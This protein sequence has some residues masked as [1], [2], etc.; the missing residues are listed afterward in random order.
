MKTT[1]EISDGLLVEAKRRAAEER[2]SLRS[3]I[4]RGLREQLAPPKHRL[5]PKARPVVH[6]ITVDGGLPEGLQ[7]EDRAAMS[8]WLRHD[9]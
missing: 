5:R 1:V 2:C 6:W 7:L 9:A 4:E 8:E 3:I